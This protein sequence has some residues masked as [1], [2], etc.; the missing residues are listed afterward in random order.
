[1]GFVGH[2]PSRGWAPHAAQRFHMA[3]KSF[4]KIDLKAGGSVGIDVDR[5]ARKA[6][7]VF[8]GPRGGHTER[9]SLDDVDVLRLHS[10][11]KGVHEMLSA[12]APGWLSPE[13]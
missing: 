3:M 7:V 9:L 10:A 13:E 6:E 2:Q 5:E 8:T 12:T 1:M 11:L 4:R